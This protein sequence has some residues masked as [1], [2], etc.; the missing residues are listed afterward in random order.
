MEVFDLIEP[1]KQLADN[2]LP[3]SDCVA[4]EMKRYTFDAIKCLQEYANVIPM[5][6]IWIALT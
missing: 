5:G 3:N 2:D 1:V 4:L 6:K